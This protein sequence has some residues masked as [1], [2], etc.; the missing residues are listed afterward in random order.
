MKHP[1]KYTDSFISIFANIL[2]QYDVQ[3]VLDPFAG[4]G[5]IIEIRN[6]GY[7]GRIICN[8]IE[9]EW[10]EANKHN[11]AQWFSGDAAL[12]YKQIPAGS[13]DAIC[14]SPT[15]GNRMADSH[16]A[17]DGSKRITYTHTLGR[18]LTDGNTGNMQWGKKYQEKHIECYK[19][20]Y[21]LLKV[22]GICIIN[23]SNHI[24]KGKEVDVIEWHKTALSNMF[25]FIE[26]LKIQTPRMGFG[27][28]SKLRTNTES[29]LIFRK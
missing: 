20:F 3:I 9:P 23:V 4:T 22:G 17:K 27:K 8:E 14:T 6:Y 16:N 21:E 26:E 25:T 10:V 28:N 5:K 18:K 12:L 19:C 24:R 7:L 11:G 13:I 15:Y 2:L 1:A 29:I